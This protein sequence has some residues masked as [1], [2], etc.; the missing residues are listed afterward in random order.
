MKLVEPVAQALA[1]VRV[2]DHADDAGDVHVLRR[3]HQVEVD[4]VAALK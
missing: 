1:D 2:L 3:A 4:D